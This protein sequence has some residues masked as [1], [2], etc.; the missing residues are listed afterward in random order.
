MRWRVP[1]PG[2]RTDAVLRLCVRP[3]TGMRALVRF[4]TL[5]LALT[6]VWGSVVPLRGQPTLPDR[7]R[8]ARIGAA[9]V[10]ML[11]F[12]GLDVA[13]DVMARVFR[14][15]G[16]RWAVS[17]SPL[18]ATVSV[19][20]RDGVFLEAFGRK[21]QGPGE[22][23]GPVAVVQ[24][25]EELWVFDSRNLRITR[26]SADF[27]IIDSRAIPGPAH[28]VAPAA[29]SDRVLL[30]GFFGQHA[31]ARVG[32]DPAQDV[33]GGR[34]PDVKSVWAQRVYAAESG[35]EVWTVAPQGGAI[36]LMRSGDLSRIASFK[37]PFKPFERFTP[38]GSPPSSDGKKE[39]PP[40]AVVGLMA[41][42]QGLIW[43]IAVQPDARWAPDGSLYDDPTPQYDTFVVA[44]DVQSRS[45]VGKARIDDVCMPVDRGFISCVNQLGESIRILRLRLTR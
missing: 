27:D 35:D 30:T 43:L 13:P 29:D 5:A 40:P 23:G 15:P 20:D 38:F 9:E 26:L 21:G 32:A 34:I 28:Y 4:V 41:D 2:M 16:S 17:S 8:G 42:G 33:T 24:N 7:S 45:V 37:L 25:G 39:A 1:E 44:I 36:Q 11:S 6:A 18:G 19:F 3:G 10:A 31:I 12:R 14:I 22:F